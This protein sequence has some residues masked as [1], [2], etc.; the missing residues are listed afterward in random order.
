MSDLAQF[1]NKTLTPTSPISDMLSNELS[2]SGVDY[3]FESMRKFTG[4]LWG[5]KSQLG[6]DQI[7]QG[8]DD[9]ETALQQARI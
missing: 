9:Y 5:S 3:A 7:P 8:L 1:S 2:K 6:K 4:F